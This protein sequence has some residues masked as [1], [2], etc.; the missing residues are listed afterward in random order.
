[1]THVVLSALTLQAVK[2]EALSAHLKH[3]D[4]GGSLFDPDMTDHE[5]L[6]ILMEEVGEVAHALTYDAGVEKEKL[7]KELLQV[8]A[9]AASWVEYIEGQETTVPD[10]FP[11]PS[12][13]G[14][15]KRITKKAGENITTLGYQ[16]IADAVCNE[17][18]IEAFAHFTELSYRR[19]VAGV[20][21]I[22]RGERYSGG[23]FCIPGP[24]QQALNDNHL[25]S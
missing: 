13:A 10:L 1:M 7:A 15:V 20:M 6:A 4:G 23:V 22:L 5:R 11:Y 21:N 2:S 16:D 9:V 8:C 14:M 3:K 25:Q 18:P 24:V 17:L 19:Y 12:I